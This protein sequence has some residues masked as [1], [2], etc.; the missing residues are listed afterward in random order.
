MQARSAPNDFSKQKRQTRPHLRDCLARG[1]LE[2]DIFA[3]LIFDK[4]P[5][6]EHLVSHADVLWKALQS[7]NIYSWSRKQNL[8]KHM[9][10]ESM[11]TAEPGLTSYAVSSPAAAGKP[12]GLFGRH[13]RRECRLPPQNMGCKSGPR[14]PAATDGYS[15]VAG[16][17][18]T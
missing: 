6:P 16:R 3:T 15:H 4:N 17:A 14:R 8:Y 5:D 1:F 13:T 18:A 2:D 12:R 7:N 10:T 11:V 9:A